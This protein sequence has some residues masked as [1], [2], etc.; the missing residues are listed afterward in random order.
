M[1]PSVYLQ[2]WTFKRERGDAVSVLQKAWFDSVFCAVFLP[3]SS[4]PPG[5][6]LLRR[7][8]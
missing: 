4:F 3:A 8:C 2:S 5:S 6:L 7:V 1:F